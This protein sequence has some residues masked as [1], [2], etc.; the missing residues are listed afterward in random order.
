VLPPFHFRQPFRDMG[1]LGVELSR[2]EKVRPRFGQ[3]ALRQVRVPVHEGRERKDLMGRTG[4]FGTW[5]RF[6]A[7]V[8]P[9]PTD[10]YDD[11]DERDDGR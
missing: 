2:P 3:L 5:S 6:L 10:P 9:T 1:A 8:P 4:H 11:R 7:P